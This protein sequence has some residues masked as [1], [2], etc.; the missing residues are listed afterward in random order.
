[1]FQVLL[2]VLFLSFLTLGS[3]QRYEATASPLC[4]SDLHFLL[5]TH[6]VLAVS[7]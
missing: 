3:T 6:L 4:F 1:L 7:C 2:R 5:H